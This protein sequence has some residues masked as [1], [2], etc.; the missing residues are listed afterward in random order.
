MFNTF[1]RYVRDINAKG[2][3]I[4]IMMLDLQKAFDT[5]DHNILCNKLEV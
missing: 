2:L 4:G 1:V 5:L 3:Y